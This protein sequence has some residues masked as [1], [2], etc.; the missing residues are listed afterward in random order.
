M[1][2]PVKKTSSSKPG[3]KKGKQMYSKKLYED[4]AR[5]LGRSMIPAGAAGRTMPAVGIVWSFV[6]L[7]EKDNPRF[8]EGKF[9]ATIEKAYLLQ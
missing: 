5:I 1:S 9:R 7:F 4:V 2:A 6:N 3:S 8:D